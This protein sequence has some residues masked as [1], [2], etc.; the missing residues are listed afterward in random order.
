MFAFANHLWSETK[1][2]R[3]RPSNS[4]WEEQKSVV[5]PQSGVIDLPTKQICGFLA[6]W[7]LK[8]LIAGPFPANPVASSLCHATT[9]RTRMDA[10]PFEETGRVFCAT[11]PLISLTIRNFVYWMMQ[12]FYK[13]YYWGFICLEWELSDFVCKAH[14]FIYRC[15]KTPLIHAKIRHFIK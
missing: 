15:W 7:P 11:T 14:D 6:V 12:V 13:S 1:T 2:T 5:L 8:Y 3:P 4:C 9:W 10:P